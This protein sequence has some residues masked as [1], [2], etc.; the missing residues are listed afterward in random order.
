MLRRKKNG[1]ISLCCR[2]TFTDCATISVTLRM[3][4]PL[5]DYAYY[6]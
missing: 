3:W 5:C 1:S 6:A 4:A 2:K